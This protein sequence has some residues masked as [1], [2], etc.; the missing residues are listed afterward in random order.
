VLDYCYSLWGHKTLSI[1]PLYGGVRAQ[2]GGIIFFSSF[3]NVAKII[4]L[5]S[6]VTNQNKYIYIYHINVKSIS[7]RI[8]IQKSLPLFLFV[9]YLKI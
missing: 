8:S 1:R 3:Y 9:S 6:T 4:H 2:R 7:V 5:G